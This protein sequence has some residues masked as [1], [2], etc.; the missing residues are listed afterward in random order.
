[1]TVLIA[2]GGIAGLTLGLT[3]HQ[4]GVPFR[5]FESVREMRPLG[6][7]INLQP[8]AV[9]ELFDLGLESQLDR[10]GVQ[11]RQYGFYSR[12]GK[13]IWEEPRGTWAGYHWPQYSV[14]RGKL[15]MMLY[16]TLCN[17]AGADCV[18][19]GA[20]AT[21]FTN[22]D[23]GAELHLDGRASETGALI[24]GADG[25]HSAI[26]AQM[27]PGEGPPIWG[28]AIL[29]RGTTQATPFFGGAAMAL[30]GHDTQRL[31]A[32]PISKPDPATGKAT[33]N[34]IAEKRVDPAQGWR[35]EDWNRSADIAEFLPDFEAWRFGWLDAPALIRG[36]EVV[37]E[38]PM[39]DRDPLDGW[40]EGRVT[41]M[42][43]AAHPT[44]PV[45]SNGAS[46]AIV[47]ART[48]GA[49]LLEHG[50][51]PGALSAYEAEMRPR[52]TAIIRANRGAGPD[53]IL[54]RV[55]DLC[56]GDFETIDDVIP[57]AE[58]AAHAEK[59]KQLAGFSVEALNAQPSLIPK[60]A[61]LRPRSG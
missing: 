49:R 11:T 55:E 54:Q 34:W 2:G 35:R 17:R 1:M 44:Y 43:D 52:T 30:T 50:V 37:Y 15:Q 8:N 53:A 24:V 14:H 12:L 7:G 48:I 33:I 39:V 47:D 18:V 31:V 61:H 4:I 38:Y 59:Y 41:L 25:I 21:G 51:T 29:W 9:R 42:G 13:T 58:L 45:G 10:I 27:N 3:L 20:R 19:T 22:H 23:H 32:Y 26:R 16:E 56:G 6:V 57:Y 36:A 46:Q 40:T 60:D 28:G 5:V